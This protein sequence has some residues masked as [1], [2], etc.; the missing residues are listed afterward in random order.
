MTVSEAFVIDF[1]GRLRHLRPH[2][3]VYCDLSPGAVP[4]E[5]CTRLFQVL[6]Q[7]EDAAADRPVEVRG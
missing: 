5:A 7:S 4:E 6:R 1:G 3:S 2:C